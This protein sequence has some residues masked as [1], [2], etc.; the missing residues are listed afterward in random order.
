M[1]DPENSVVERKR[2][3]WREFAAVLLLSVTA[4]VTAWAGFQSSKWRGEMSISFSEASSARIEA[5]RQD[6]TAN[7]KLTVQVTLFTQWLDAYQGGDQEL[8][9][10]LQTRFPEPLRTAFPVWLASEPLKNPDAAPT[11]FDQPDFVVAE[12][13]AA[14]DAD[15]RADAKFDEALVYNDRGDEYTVLTVGLATVLFFAAMSGR[16]HQRR[17]QWVLL[18]LAGVGFL[19][20]TGLLLSFPK[21]I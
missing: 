21:L 19:V 13:T 17:T 8:S 6:G 20:C 14:Q 10:F 7:R 9:T 18:A 16:M 2:H 3:D 12:Q 5:A 15:A 11:P 4:I 1:P